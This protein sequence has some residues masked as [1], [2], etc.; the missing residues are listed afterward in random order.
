MAIV[1]RPSLGVKAA[2]RIDRASDV[3]RH[4]ANER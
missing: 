1:A 3:C 4:G 2:E